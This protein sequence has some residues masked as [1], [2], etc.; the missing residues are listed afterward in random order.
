VISQEACSLLVGELLHA[1]HE[2]DAV[3]AALTVTEAPVALER[4][5]HD[6]AARA[7]MAADRA[8][9]SQ[10]FAS[11]LQL[12]AEQIADLLDRDP[13]PQGFEVHTLVSA[14]WCNLSVEGTDQCYS[15]S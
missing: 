3:A 10:L 6:K 8:G 5:S 14:H 1:S 2:L 12:D 4:R 13:P 7:V 9:A 15:I 11:L